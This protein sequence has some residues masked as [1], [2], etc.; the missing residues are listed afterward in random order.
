MSIIV[1]AYFKI[2]SN[3]KDSIYF[4]R[5]IVRSSLLVTAD[6]GLA[7]GNSIKDCAGVS[8][9]HSLVSMVPDCKDIALKRLSLVI[10]F[11]KGSA[12]RKEQLNKRVRV[13]GLEADLGLVIE[14]LQ[15][16]ILKSYLNDSLEYEPSIWRLWASILECIGE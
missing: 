14:T 13:D 3:L 1:S 15:Y 12:K 11:C 6:G 7:G 2:S 5:I 10:E 9:V 8:T 16:M 4:D